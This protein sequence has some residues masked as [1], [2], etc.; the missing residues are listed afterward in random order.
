MLCIQM[1]RKYSKI[2]I[3]A[4]FQLLKLPLSEFVRISYIQFLILIYCAFCTKIIKYLFCFINAPK[5]L[6]IYFNYIFM[7]SDD[8]ILKYFP[9]ILKIDSFPEIVLKVSYI[10]HNSAR[11]HIIL[12]LYRNIVEVFSKKF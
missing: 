7:H 5:S 2:S 9:K 10:A 6:K 12:K 11:G 1:A 4:D 3:F 8:S